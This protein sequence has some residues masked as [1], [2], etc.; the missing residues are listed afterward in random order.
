MYLLFL[1]ST[2]REIFAI[3]LELE[4]L[5]GGVVHVQEGA[6]QVEIWGPQEEVLTNKDWGSKVNENHRQA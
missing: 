3:M 6:E 1:L 4:V 2:C 5:Q